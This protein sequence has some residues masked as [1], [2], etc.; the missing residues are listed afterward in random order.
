MTNKITFLARLFSVLSATFLAVSCESDDICD[1]TVNTPRLVV[2]FYN[3][4]NTRTPMSIAN[5]TIYGEGNST[6]LVSSATLDSIA[7][8]LRLQNP[9]TYLFQTVVSGTT[10]STATLTLTYN[11]EETFVSKACGI[12]TTYNTLSATIQD[13]NT[14]WLKGVTIKNNTIDNEKKAHIHL[15]H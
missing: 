15:Y 5:L 1:H 10:T 13:A 8:P 6:P 11:T 3:A 2:R 14:S 7:L 4:N 12:K 9:T